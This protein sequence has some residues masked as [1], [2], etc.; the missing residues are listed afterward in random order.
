CSFSG[1]P[2]KFSPQRADHLLMPAAGTSSW[3]QSA[4]AVRSGR[5]DFC[6][7]GESGHITVERFTISCQ[8]CERLWSVTGA[9]SVYER[10]AM[11]SC[12]CPHCGA[13]TLSYQD[14]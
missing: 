14:P 7:A 6:Y 3:Q 9:L 10:Q 12:P 5:V 13:Y 2:L 1:W 8:H 11:E 4:A